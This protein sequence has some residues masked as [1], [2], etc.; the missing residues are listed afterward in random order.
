MIIAAAPWTGIWQTVALAAGEMV[1]W[2]VV[3][4]AIRRWSGRAQQRLQSTGDLRDRSKAKRFETIGR[5]FSVAA[6][7]VIAIV[8]A[9]MGLAVWGVPIA[10]IV[11]SLS[12]V[13]IAVGFGAQS[14]IKD[15]IAGMFVLIE[16]Q[17]AIGDV[18]ELAGASGTVEEIRLRTTVLRGL[19][20]SVY[21]I[22]NGEVRVAKNLT[23]EYSR[24]AIDISVAYEEPVDRV[25][26]VIAD[27]ASSFAADPEWS[28]RLIDETSVLGVDEL[29]DSGV[30]IRVLLTTDPDERWAVKREFLR[31]IKNRFDAEGIEI[32]YPH[33]TVNRRS[34]RG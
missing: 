23:H 6:F 28:D 19:D 8:A 27:E 15:L 14:F 26:S 29:A 30:T 17:Y 16:D 25:M 5:S 12:V 18:V 3:R 33:V 24:F 13:G 10:P 7:I 31:R 1:T 22:P 20:G 34:E 9:A 32:P 2:L 11:A 21:H 4:F